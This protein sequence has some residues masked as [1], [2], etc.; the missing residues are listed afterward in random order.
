MP[1]SGGLN[2]AQPKLVPGSIR[3]SVVCAL[4]LA[5]RMN[6]KKTV[7]SNFIVEKLCAFKKVGK[8]FSSYLILT[9]KL[10]WRTPSIPLIV[11]LILLHVK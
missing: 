1:V 6:G 11:L 4:N 7:K 10:Q 8:I 2:M 5:K 3:R 9:K